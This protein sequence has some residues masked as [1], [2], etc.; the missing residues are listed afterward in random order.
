MIYLIT[1]LINNNRYIG[2]TKH[3]LEHR[4]KQHVYNAVSGKR[5]RLS[6]AIRKYGSHNFKIEYLCDGLDDEEIKMIAE[7]QPEY[8]MT[9]GG[10]GGRTADSP[11]YKAGMKTRKSVKGENNPMYGKRGADNPNFGK[12]YGPN[13]LISRNT[14]KLLLSS[15]NICFRGFEDM[16][17]Y[18][19]VMSYYSLKKKGITW[20][21][22]IDETAEKSS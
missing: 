4:W 20:R 5:F 13:P 1:N 15:E 7:H 2:K 6:I 8:N 17:S 21:E 3:S 22:I 9:L 18:Y 19:G 11:N 10:D 16:F 12:K 14:K